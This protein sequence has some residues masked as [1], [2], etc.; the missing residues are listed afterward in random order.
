MKNKEELTG[1][2]RVDVVLPG[3]KK[4]HF[5]F[6]P[7]PSKPADDQARVMVAS[8]YGENCFFSVVTA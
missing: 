3:G 8:V 1:T 4:D 5:H 6:T 2:H 7:F